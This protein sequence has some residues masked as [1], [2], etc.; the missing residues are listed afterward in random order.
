MVDEDRLD[1]LLT[2]DQTACYEV[3]LIEG[4][5]PEWMFR[6]FS[7]P[8]LGRVPAANLAALFAHLQPVEVR[9]GDT[10][11]RQGENGDYYYL[12]RRGRAEVHQS[13]GNAEPIRVA[14]LDAGFGFGEEAL[15]TGDPRN[16]TVTMLE[17]GLLMRLSQK[18]FN[19]LLQ[20]SLIK[21]IEPDA[22][23]SLLRNGARLIDVRTEA[24]AREHPIANSINMPLSNLRHLSEGLDRAGR[25]VTVCRT[26]RRCAAAAFLLSQRGF[27]VYILKDDS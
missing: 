1:E 25:Y 5:D 20:P 21:R 15:I 22:L 12:I 11:V 13:V 6:L 3:G 24:E 9:A 16:A 10:I 23:L 8:A 17:D 2:A 26:G 27:D 4:E 7:S 14:I 19:T 18:D